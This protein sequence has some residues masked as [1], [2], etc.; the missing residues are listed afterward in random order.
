[1]KL[2]FLILTMSCSLIIKGQIKV[3]K[4]LTQ[5]IKSK[6][7]V[8]LIANNAQSVMVSISKLDY[9]IISSANFKLNEDSIIELPETYTQEVKSSTN[10]TKINRGWTE[11][12][13]LKVENGYTIRFTESI[14]TKKSIQLNTGIEYKAIKLGGSTS[15]DITISNSKQTDIQKTVTSDYTKTIETTLQPGEK[16]YAKATS[17][18]K[19]IKVPFTCKFVFD[20]DVDFD[21]NL[22]VPCRSIFTPPG[23]QCVNF[24][25]RTTKKLSDILSEE[26]RTFY[27]KGFLQNA[28]SSAISVT[29]AS[30]ILSERQCDTVFKSIDPM[31]TSEYISLVS[32]IVN[33]KALTKRNK[34]T[35]SKINAGESYFLKNSILVSNTEYE[36][37]NFNLVI[38][39]YNDKITITTANVYSKIEVQHWSFGPGFCNV[40]TRTPRTRVG[41]NAPPFT[42][43]GWQLL[44]NHIG[45]VTT[46]IT[47]E[48][49]CDT[50]VKS[51]VRYYKN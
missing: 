36:K 13:T 7:L 12:F 4:E 15:N 51:Q 25:S 49:N 39:D 11:T 16:L 29:Y 50:G 21:I 18:T 9:N 2:I 6:N 24:L 10:C 47:N 34:Q 28:S 14:E 46:T 30:K 33:T 48:V 35:L 37:I 8:S 5:R 19:N 45:E 23:S 32:S 17:L 1:M 40:I 43:S 31:S 41:I 44:T 27:I 42:W 22:I 3:D 20:G 38:E 26:E